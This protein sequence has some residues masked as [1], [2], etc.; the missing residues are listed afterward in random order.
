MM[1]AIQN[2]LGFAG[3]VIGIIIFVAIISR[4]LS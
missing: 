1:D 4:C 2:F 3:Q